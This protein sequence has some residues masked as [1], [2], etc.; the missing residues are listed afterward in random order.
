MQSRARTGAR[1]FLCATDA[2]GWAATRGDPR[3]GGGD[4]D[5]WCVAADGRTDC[6]IDCDIYWKRQVLAEMSDHEVTWT[7][8]I[9]A[10]FPRASVL[11]IVS[12]FAALLYSCEIAGPRLSVHPASDGADIHGRFLGEYDLGFARVRINDLATGITV[13]EQAALKKSFGA[14]QCAR[15]AQAV[16]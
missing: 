5:R 3:S 13:C 16:H 10:S 6:D 2:C 15:D 1:L 4:R 14:P 12:T 9:S 7:S 8:R 11:V